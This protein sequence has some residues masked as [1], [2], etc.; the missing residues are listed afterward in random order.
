MAPQQSLNID[1]ARRTVTV[2]GAR[3]H[4]HLLSEFVSVRGPV[5]EEVRK[6][7]LV[8]TLLRQCAR[9]VGQVLAA[10]ALM[11]AEFCTCFTYSH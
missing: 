9:C 6:V 2:L 7:M 4:K 5:A 1:V 10:F 3:S 11:L 8:E